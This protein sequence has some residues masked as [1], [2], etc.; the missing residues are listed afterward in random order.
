MGLSGCGGPG[1]QGSELGRSEANHPRRLVGPSALSAQEDPGAPRRPLSTAVTGTGKDRAGGCRAQ[2]GA[3]DRTMIRHSEGR[4]HGRSHQGAAGGH[5]KT[6]MRIFFFVQKDKSQEETC[7]SLL[8]QK[9]EKKVNTCFFAPDSR[10]LRT[11]VPLGAQ[12]GNFRRNGLHGG[13]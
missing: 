1:V 6:K 13:Q 8:D 2:P 7:V 11:R 9:G 3:A 12:G 4:A 5:R 10:M